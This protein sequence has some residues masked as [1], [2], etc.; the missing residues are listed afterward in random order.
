VNATGL[1]TYFGS[2]LLRSVQ[3]GLVQNY[4]LVIVAAL[5]AFIALFQWQALNALV[6]RLVS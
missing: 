4:A 3:S 1:A 2:L 5:L 6:Q